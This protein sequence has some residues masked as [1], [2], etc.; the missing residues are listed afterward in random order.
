MSPWLLFALAAPFCW[1]IANVIDSVVRRRFVKNDYAM[2]WFLGISRLIFIVPL[3][4][5]IGENPWSDSMNL[6]FMLL[7]GF[8]WLFPFIFYYKAMEFEETS[9]VVIFVQMLPLFSLIM[10][11]FLIGERLNSMQILA[12][13]FLLSGGLLASLKRIGGNVRISRALP[14]MMLA[15]FIWALSDVLF[16]KHAEAFGTFGNA[17]FWYLVGGFLFSMVFFFTNKGRQFVHHHFAN[18][19]KRAW[20]LL[21]IDQIIGMTGSLSIA[22]ALTLGKA[23]LTVVLMGIQPLIAFGMTFL[24]RPFIPEIEPEDTATGVLVKK[25]LSLALIITGLFFLT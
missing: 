7:A 2:T 25:G 21:G 15:S 19:S 18:L 1:G 13:V 3:L 22:Y 10:A 6:G 17:F 8:F 12:F 14:L 4:F 16:K 5:V 11:F 9:R 23:S 20:W 24:L